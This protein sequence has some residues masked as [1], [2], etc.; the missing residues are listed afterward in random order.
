MQITVTTV[1]G[2]FDRQTRA[3]AEYRVFSMLAPFSDQ[4]QR[5][6]IA[7]TSPADEEARTACRITVGLAQ[8][9][10]AT[11]TAHG[12]HACDAVDRAAVRMAGFI[13]R[14]FTFP[15]RET[16][17]VYRV[18]GDLI[19]TEEARDLAQQLVAWHD[20]MVK[21]LRQVRLRG[22]GCDEECPHEQARALWR[23]AVAVFGADADKLTFL[24]AHGDVA[25]IGHGYSE[26]GGFGSL[27][28][29]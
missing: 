14:H 7:L 10:S 19:G 8:G 28:A 23:L 12:D 15:R 22:A 13:D 24:Q 18:L 1:G 6:D 29:R 17:N 25:T 9:M 4:A 5:I 26:A 11:V 2:D 27:S 16:V 20:S 21:H 3:Y